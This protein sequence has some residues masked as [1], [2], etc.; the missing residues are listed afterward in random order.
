MI[1]YKKILPYL[2]AVLSFIVIAYMFTPQVFSGKVV[3]Q[4][5]I[6]SWRGMANEIISYNYFLQRSKS[7]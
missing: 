1:N 5:D 6:A 2:I 3:N 4:G 7:G